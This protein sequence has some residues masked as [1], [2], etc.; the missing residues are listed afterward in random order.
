METIEEL[1]KEAFGSLDENK[2]DK[3]F[4]PQMN[5]FIDTIL[6]KDSNINTDSQNTTN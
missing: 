3:S 6:L 1:E 2:H 5:P 4:S